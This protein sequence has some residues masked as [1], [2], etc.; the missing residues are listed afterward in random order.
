MY[1][2][3]L[4]FN[5]TLFKKDFNMARLIAFFIAGIL[6]ITTTAYVISAYNS[7]KNLEKYYIENNI[8]YNINELINDT[9]SRLADELG[10]N[11]YGADGPDILVSILGPIMVA[12]ILFGEEKR[13]KTFEVLSVMPYT[14]YEIFFNK[15]LVALSVIVIPFIING[16]IMLIGLGVNSSLRNFYSVNQVLLWMCRGFYYQLPI[17]SF[18]ILFGVITGTTISQIAL[19]IIF[20]VF[21]AGFIMLLAFNLEYLGFSS[22]TNYISGHILYGKFFDYFTLLGVFESSIHGEKFY[23]YYIVLSIIFIIISKFL[24][25][26][27]KIERN[28]ETLEFEKTEG[29]FKFGVALCTALLMAIIF[30]LF[31]NDYAYVFAINNILI[32]ILGYIFGGA[33]GYFIAN[34]S[35]KA[36]RS[37][38]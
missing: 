29:F 1:L 7:L 4:P 10:D 3:M 20:A 8:D 27:N 19:G 34:Y 24:F 16:L 28:G 37:K 15:L 21:P 26:R 17:L 12:M 23:I 31:A 30:V 5:K 33:L 6:F 22:I 25:D 2:K 9:K 18:S 36:N 35:I 11:M 14:K 38:A 13:R 32:M